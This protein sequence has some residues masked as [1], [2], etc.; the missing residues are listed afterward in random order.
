MKKVLKV[1]PWV[2]VAVLLAVAIV[3]RVIMTKAVETWQQTA[4]RLAISKCEQSDASETSVLGAATN[5]V[6]G[7]LEKV[8]GRQLVPYYVYQELVF[9][10]VTTH[11]Y[12]LEPKFDLADRLVAFGANLTLGIR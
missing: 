10:N 5:E 4:Y 11:Y 3:D 7:A 9:R 6:M 2:L 12:E 1:L 8:S